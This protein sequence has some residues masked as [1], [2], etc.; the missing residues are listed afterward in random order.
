MYIYIYTYYKNIIPVPHK[1]RSRC[2]SLCGFTDGRNPSCCTFTFTR[3]EAIPRN[4]SVFNNF[5][6]QV[7]WSSQG[8][9]INQELLAT[10]LKL[11]FL[12]TFP[13]GSGGQEKKYKENMKTL[14][15]TRVKERE[16]ERKKKLAK[17][18]GKRRTNTETIKSVGLTHYL[19]YVL[20]TKCCK[21]HLLLLCHVHQLGGLHFQRLN[22][23][24]ANEVQ[25]VKLRGLRRLCFLGVA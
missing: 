22:S 10:Q 24:H 25:Q 23:L 12:V 8:Q 14:C 15:F 16:R 18:L 11:L 1:V 17:C 4:R 19:I 3:R 6:A 5:H 7:F 9:P 21:D 2:F 13:H 20:E